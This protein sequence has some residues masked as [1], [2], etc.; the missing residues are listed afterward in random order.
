MR[1][2]PYL[3]ERRSNAEAAKDAKKD[4]ISQ[5]DHG[6]SRTGLNL[7]VLPPALKLRRGSPKRLRR[8]GGR[9]LRGKSKDI[10]IAMN[11]LQLLLL[12]SLGTLLAQS[13]PAGLIVSAQPRPLRIIAF[14]AHPD[15]AELKAGGAATL[16]AAEGH[17]VK[18]VAM[19]NG[20]VGHFAAAG[21]PLAQRRKAEVAECARIFGIENGVFSRICGSLPAPGADPTYGTG[22]FLSIDTIESRR[23]FW[24]SVSPCC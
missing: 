24:W 3:T 23:P 22:R 1:Q 9:I 7:R 6:R 18:F 19:T 20:D 14:G 2:A 13:L 8:E 4:G 16:W 10:L 11:R 17:K 21:G 5:S 15:D 12:L